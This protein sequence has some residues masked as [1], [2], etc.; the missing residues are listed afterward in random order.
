MPQ[1]KTLNPTDRKR[2][3]QHARE[4]EDLLIPLSVLSKA[5]DS[6]KKDGGREKLS[7]TNPM[8]VIC[9]GPVAVHSKRTCLLCLK[10]LMQQTS[11]IRELNN[12]QFHSDAERRVCTESICKRFLLW[13]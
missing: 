2:R 1:G 7:A 12:L 13:L 6:R 4:Q 11:L 9:E 10:S 8:Q 5:M 3:K